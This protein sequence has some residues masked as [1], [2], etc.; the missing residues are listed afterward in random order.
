MELLTVGDHTTYPSLKNIVMCRES[1]INSTPTPGHLSDVVLGELTSEILEGDKTTKLTL[2]V[3]DLDN[4]YT[5]N[6]VLSQC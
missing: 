2:H 6:L 5:L 4:P 1:Y 3:N